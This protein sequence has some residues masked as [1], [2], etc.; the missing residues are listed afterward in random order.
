MP[1]GTYNKFNIFVLDIG[2]G[3]H[4]LQTHVLKCYLSNVAPIADTHTRYGATGTASPQLAEFNASAQSG[5]TT[6]GTALPAQTWT[7]STTT[8]SLSTG[9]ADIVWTAGANWTNQFQYIPLYNDTQTSPADPLI[10][11]WD[12]GSALTLNNGETFTV[13]FGTNVF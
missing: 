13:D 5:Y 1:T 6:G 12:Y 9:G 7:R 3:S 4:V 11:W 8:A 10:A 2:Q